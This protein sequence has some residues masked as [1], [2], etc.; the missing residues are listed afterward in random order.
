MKHLDVLDYTVWF[1][2][3]TVHGGNLDHIL[4]LKNKPHLDI[5][6]RDMDAALAKA[7]PELNPF[8]PNR[9][10]H[11]TERCEHGDISFRL[12]VSSIDQIT[13]CLEICNKTISRWKSIYKIDKMVDSPQYA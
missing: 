7:Y 13:P 3:N 11:I 9:A 4:Y 5:L 10:P 2:I 1:F 8:E 12:W 6:E